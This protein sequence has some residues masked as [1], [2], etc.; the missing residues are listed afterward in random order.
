[1]GCAQ[2]TATKPGG[3]AESDDLLFLDPD[4]QCV[5]CMETAG[6]DAA[7]ENVEAVHL[8]QLLPLL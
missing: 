2:S 5:M 4:D 6:E 3:L 8:L 7:D 1:M